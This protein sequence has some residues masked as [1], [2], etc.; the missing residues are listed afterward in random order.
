MDFLQILNDYL[1]LAIFGLLGAM[2]FVGIWLGI[3]RMVF[4]WRVKPQNFATENALKEALSKNLTTLYIIYQ[5]APYVG[6]LGTVGGIILTF[7]GMSTH[8]F[9]DP[10]K[11]MRDLSLALQAT[12]AGLVVAI[13]VLVIYNIFLRKM[14]V[15]LARFQDLAHDKQ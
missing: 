8:A 4:F 7:Y 13:P 9:I 1:D 11:I 12:G 2:G 6:L 14:D 3:E 5:N 10:Q 15:I